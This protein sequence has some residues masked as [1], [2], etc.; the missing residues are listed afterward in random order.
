MKQ[1]K[2]L[3]GQLN[4]SVKL[5]VSTRLASFSKQLSCPQRINIKASKL[6][7]TRRSLWVPAMALAT[8][9]NTSFLD[10]HHACSGIYGAGT[11][12]YTGMS[13]SLI[14]FG[15]TLTT[16]TTWVKASQSASSP[17]ALIVYSRLRLHLCDWGDGVDGCRL[18]QPFTTCTIIYNYAA[19]GD[20]VKCF[21]I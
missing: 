20:M 16:C 19:T 17:M 12:G 9:T 7:T 18:W 2:I 3:C 11:P 14:Q 8:G 5:D 10:Y 13:V 4:C 15:M 21:I 1:T 6:V